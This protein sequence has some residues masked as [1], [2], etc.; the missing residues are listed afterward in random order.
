LIDEQGR[1]KAR[2]VYVN[3]NKLFRDVND[4]AVALEGEKA[5]DAAAAA[6]AAKRA[7]ESRVISGQPA[8]LGTM[9]SMMHV[10]SMYESLNTSI[11]VVEVD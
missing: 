5:K 9:E 6:T 8:Q 2:K 3:P 7:R 10:F 4:V 11:V 1:T